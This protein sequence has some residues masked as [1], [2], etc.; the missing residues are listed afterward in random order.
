MVEEM[1]Q[2]TLILALLVLAAVAVPPAATAAVAPTGRHLVAFERPSTARSAA[3]VSAVVSRAGARRAGR[4]VPQYGLATVR[5][6]AAAIRALRRDPAVESVSREYYRELRRVPNDPALTTPETEF[7]GLPGGAPV[8]WTLAREGFPAAWDVTT[9]DTAVV[10]VLDSGIDSAH[11]E[12]GGKI[13][14]LDA[15][16]AGSAGSDEDGHGSHVSGLACAA[17]GN[18]SGMAGAGWGCRLAF[19]K[20]PSPSIPDEAIVE[21]VRIAVARGAH[22]INMSFGGGPPNAALDLAINDAVQKGVVLVAAASNFAD[23]DQGAPASQLQPGDAPNIDAG[24]GLVVTAAD[25]QDRRASTG[26][27]AQISLAAYGFFHE[28]QGPPGLLSTYTSRNPTTRETLRLE[29]DQNGIPTPVPPCDCRRDFGGDNRYAYLQGTSMATPQVTALA[30]LLGALNPSLS[31]PEKLRLIK[32]TARRSGGWNG[33]LGWGIV[34]AGRALDAARR[35]DRVAPSSKART[36]RRARPRR[37][38][39]RVAVRVRWSG[40]D[41]ASAGLIS[42]GVRTYE[43]FMRRGR[44]RARRIRSTARKTARLKLKP[45]TYRFFTRALDAAGNR[46]A[47]PRTA[48]ARLVVKRP[49]K[50]KRRRR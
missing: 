21:A 38:R 12:L 35:I 11:P 30:A 15:V 18:G 27:G 49:R 9:G 7:G 24:R 28:T 46:E 33:D 37:G 25:F 16:Q 8:Q 48:D 36:R 26:F 20:L 32:E 6:S 22:A 2:R 19:V 47:A 3:A 5:G 13:A 10:G 50:P 14:S 40:G 39:R 1:R 31:V 41:A 17:T 29:P 44:G 42:S 34:D 4:G 43:L 45:G 23:S